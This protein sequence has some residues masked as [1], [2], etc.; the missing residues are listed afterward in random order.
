MSTY[1]WNSWHHK[2]GDECPKYLPLSAVDQPWPTEDVEVGYAIHMTRIY[3]AVFLVQEVVVD[4]HLVPC[5]D[6]VDVYIIGNLKVAIHSKKASQRTIDGVV[7][8]D[9]IESNMLRVTEEEL[10]LVLRHVR[11][12]EEARG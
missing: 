8:C 5:G 6:K 1:Q 11:R 10:R 2:G 12:V 7:E 4:E 3:C 9:A